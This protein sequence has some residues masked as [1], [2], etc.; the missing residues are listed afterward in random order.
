MLE[1]V[2][3]TPMKIF[4]KTLTVAGAS[5]LLGGTVGA[6]IPEKYQTI[7]DRNA[8]GLLPPPPP[9]AETNNLAAPPANLKVTGFATIGGERRVFFTIPPKDPKEVQQ[10]LSFTE[11][12]RE[13]SIEVL[14]ISETE[15][16]VRIK[17][18]TIESVL[19]LKKDGFAPAKLP[20]GANQAPMPLGAPPQPINPQVNSPVYSPESAGGVVANQTSQQVPG[21]PAQQNGGQMAQPMNQPISDDPGATM[22]P[23][24]NMSA[25][26]AVR[27]IPTRTLRVPPVSPQSSVTPPAPTSVVYSPD[28]NSG[29][30]G[31]GHNEPQEPTVDPAI[32]IAAMK[33]YQNMVNENGGVVPGGP[34]PSRPNNNSPVYAPPSPSGRPL[35][36]PPSPPIY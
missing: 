26:G 5:V 29:G 9:P 12:Q 11:G 15:G 25:P 14:S 22:Q 33:E 31:G 7:L 2:I 27:T 16:E 1:Q 35:P 30:N 6:V 34:A 13:G 10:Y 17:N 18:G 24:S 20:P 36:A 4:A 32:Q 8:F 23:A 19:S 28:F 21:Y 3:F